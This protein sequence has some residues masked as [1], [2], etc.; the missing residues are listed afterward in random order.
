M[1]EDDGSQSISLTA[2]DFDQSSWASQRET[3]LFLDS[4]LR[5]AE[6][7]RWSRSS[8]LHVA[9]ENPDSYEKKFITLGS[10]KFGGG[11][12]RDPYFPL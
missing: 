8:L 9:A 7:N 5:R 1:M 12:R 11:I 4:T 10:D 6:G 3:L 2:R